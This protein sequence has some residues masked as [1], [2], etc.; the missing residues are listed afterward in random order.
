MSDF[1]VGEIAV[2]IDPGKEWHGDEVVIKSNLLPTETDVT[3]LLGSYLV[4]GEPMYEIEFS[5]GESGTAPPRQLR[6]KR[7]PEESS[8][9]RE[10]FEKN[11]KI[12]EI[13]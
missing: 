13:A 2:V 3:H 7:P 10:W 4:L 9:A 1:K 11:I 5:D 6:K 12:K 8:W